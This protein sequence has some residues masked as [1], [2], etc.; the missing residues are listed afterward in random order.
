MDDLYRKVNN[1]YLKSYKDP[2]L[3]LIG[4]CSRS[5]KSSLSSELAVRFIANS[6]GTQIITLDSW[7]VPVDER[8]FKSLVTNRFDLNAARQAVD[9]L[10]RKRIA[11]IPIYDPILRGSSCKPNTQ[12]TIENKTIL[13]VEGVVALCD[14]SLLARSNLK[15]FVDVNDRLRIKR[16]IKFYRDIKKLRRDVY[17]NIIQEREDEEVIFIKKSAIRANLIF[18]N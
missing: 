18:K 10:L 1:S 12:I 17:K 16:L 6:I 7:I 8:P 13:I 5:G 14:D 11:E 9:L 4:G 2:F 15:I 3:I